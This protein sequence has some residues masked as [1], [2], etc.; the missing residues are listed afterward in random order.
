MKTLL[1]ETSR[2]DWAFVFSASLVWALSLLVTLWD[3]VVLQEMT[4]RLSFVSAAGLALFIAG[5]IIRAVAKRTL[6]KYYSYGL[7]TLPEHKLVTHGIYKHIRHPIS[8][9]AIIYDIGIPLFFSSLYGFLI[10]LGLVPC[11]LYR[12][13]IEERMLLG[14][15][16]DEYRE[17]MKRTRR[18]IPYLY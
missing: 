6:G 7:R 18:M 10:M 17:Y 16:G 1:F 9:A 5:V 4:Y 13:R 12:V 3:F 14:R 15:F 2:E 8:L 11:I